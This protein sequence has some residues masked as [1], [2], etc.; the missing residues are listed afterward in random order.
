MSHAPSRIIPT[1]TVLSLLIASPLHAQEPPAATSE[2]TADT[3][4]EG[5]VLEGQAAA[6][7][8]AEVDHLRTRARK[9][10]LAALS[11]VLVSTALF[12]TAGAV[13]SGNNSQA[14]VTRK[15]MIAGF[16]LVGIGAG[17]L[18][19]AIIPAV[20]GRRARKQADRLEAGLALRP[21]VWVGR[22]TAGVGLSLRF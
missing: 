4:P 5:P 7:T 11:L 13:M 18:L 15:E 3:V 21:G 16:S 20:I 1:V 10:R 12:S 22:G 9:S 19:S 6:D 8:K 17:V 14:F 2:S